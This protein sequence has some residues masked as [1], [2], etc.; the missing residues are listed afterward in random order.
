MNCFFK[1]FFG[2]FFK[3]SVFAF[4]M[5][6]SVRQAWAQNTTPPPVPGTPVNPN[7]GSPVQSA[8]VACNDFNVRFI[9]KDLAQPYPNFPVGDDPVLDPKSINKGAVREMTAHFACHGDGGFLL[10]AATS[11]HILEL[12]DGHICHTVRTCGNVTKMGG[13]F[14]LSLGWSEFSTISEFIVS[15]DF[16]R[17]SASFDGLS[18]TLQAYVSFENIERYCAAPSAALCL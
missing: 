1:S 16:V 10:P 3:L 17:Q 8:R 9:N 12:K 14:G 13:Y 11:M 5:S 4:L 7:E 2:L 15:K 18:L 6:I